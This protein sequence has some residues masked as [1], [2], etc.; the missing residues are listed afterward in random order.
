MNAIQLFELDWVEKRVWVRSEITCDH[1]VFFTVKISGKR[2][3]LLN[4]LQTPT[5]A[6]EGDSMRRRVRAAASLFFFFRGAG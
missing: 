3:I 1:P 2:S 5:R 4:G 6:N